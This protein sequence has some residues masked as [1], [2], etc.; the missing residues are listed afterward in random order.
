MVCNICERR[1]HVREGSCG[2]CGNYINTNGSMREK[3]PHRYL[4]VEPT[5]IETVPVFN[6]FPG[7]KLLQ[8]TTT[9]CVFDCS[10]CVSTVLVKE[11]DPASKALV[12]LSPDQVVDRAVA[13]GCAGIVFLM[14]DPLASFHTF[15]A[16]AR[17][18]KK[19][20]LMVGFSSNGYFTEESLNTVIDCLDFVNI[21]LKGYSDEAYRLCGVQSSKPA[22]RTIKR[23]HEQGVHVEVS[24]IYKLG[25]RE[26]ILLAAAEVAAVDRNIPFQVMRFVPYED[27]PCGHEPSIRQAEKLVGELSSYLN[28]V[29]LFNSPGTELQDTRC[30][31]CG[32][33]VVK[34]DYWGPMGAIVRA[35]ELPDKG[36]HTCPRC[37]AQIAIKGSFNSCDC[38]SSDG[39]Y[40]YTRAL[41]IIE[42]ILVTLGVNDH[43]KVVQLWEETLG[44]KSL[45]ALFYSIQ[46]TEGYL[47]VMLEYGAKVGERARAEKVVAYYR[48]KLQEVADRLKGVTQRPR[49]YYCMGKPL[50]S[51]KA[52][53]FE[54]HIVE[55]SG[56]I[57]LNR[58]M[59]DLTGRP[60]MRIPATRVNKLDPEVIFLS[61]QYA[62]AIEDFYQDCQEAGVDVT[63]L[64]QRRV[65]NQL[66]HGWEYGSPR[67]LLGLLHS[68][69][70]LHPELFAF[71]MQKEADE[72][73]RRFYGI[74]FNPQELNHSF[75]KP[76][77]SWTWAST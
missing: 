1:C 14:N 8:I 51:V 34:R 54:N 27:A 28:Y 75:S 3:Y 64:R 45:Q 49:V 50:Y 39:G 44:G 21:G 72:F 11:I 30:P 62:G 55:L 4:L 57:S 12:E 25:N 35:K 23:L 7:T 6:Y 68:A 26:D 15:T 33:A 17:A 32:L 22:Y 59:T 19:R 42:G 41:E 53:R 60:G 52:E 71:D 40:S 46:N 67:W 61:A 24:C 73:Y 58:Q 16:V 20:G 77:I 38:D 43:R 65:Y 48:K 2:A 13:T 5:A 31:Q 36:P 66:A 74:G 18:A 63:A 70:C 76:S 9:G 10:G 56:G 29:Y 69:N 37:G 47:K